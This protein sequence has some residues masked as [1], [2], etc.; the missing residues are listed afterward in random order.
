MSES[1][2]A[3]IDF[4]DRRLSST[5]IFLLSLIQDHVL[6]ESS[7]A[8]RQSLPENSFH[9]QH[10][11]LAHYERS[12]IVLRSLMTSLIVWEHCEGALAHHNQ[13]AH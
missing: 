5:L 1:N 11:P 8:Y 10:K 2:N 6:Q 4:A 3:V 12:D 13:A 9:P 7:T